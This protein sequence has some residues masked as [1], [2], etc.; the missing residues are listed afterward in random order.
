MDMIEHNYK[1]LP[2]TNLFNNINIAKY[3]I[4]PKSKKHVGI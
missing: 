1:R 4:D 3:K 2:W